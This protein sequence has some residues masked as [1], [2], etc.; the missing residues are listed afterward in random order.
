MKEPLF[1]G[2]EGKTELKYD[3]KG[4]ILP[5][6]QGGDKLVCRIL[7]P[8]EFMSMY[9]VIAKGNRDD[10]TNFT[11]CLLLGARYNECQRI[12][13]NPKWYDASCTVK[14]PIIERTNYI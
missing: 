4:K 2:T 13:N 14:I 10:L 12:Q 3:K 8:S 1:I 5:G 7:R 6:H 9:N 11:L